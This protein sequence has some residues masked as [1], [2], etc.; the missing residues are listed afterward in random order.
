[1]HTHYKLGR[2]LHGRLPGMSRAGKHLA[3]CCEPASVFVNVVGLCLSGIPEGRHP[4][5]YQENYWKGDKIHQVRPKP[6]TMWLS[7][8]TQGTPLP[9][10]TFQ[11]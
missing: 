5:C 7:P 1:M 6:T 3:W 10:H 4:A 11:A 2:C 8:S 9:M